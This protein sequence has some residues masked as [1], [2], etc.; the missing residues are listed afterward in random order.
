MGAAATFCFP[1]RCSPCKG[2]KAASREQRDGEPEAAQTACQRGARK[3]KTGL[4]G[5]DQGEAGLRGLKGAFNAL[6]APS[7]ELGKEKVAG[8]PLPRP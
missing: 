1:K 5:E 8:G 2:R 6:K 3:T 7:S 4:E